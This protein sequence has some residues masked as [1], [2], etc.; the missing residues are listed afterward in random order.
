MS[1]QTLF[2]GTEDRFQGI[3]I[4]STKEPCDISLFPEVLKGKDPNNYFDIRTIELNEPYSTNYYNQLTLQ[5][6]KIMVD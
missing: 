3:T 5:T 4:D 2:V 1:S 6:S